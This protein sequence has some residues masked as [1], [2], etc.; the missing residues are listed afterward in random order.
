M[1]SHNIVLLSQ[2]GRLTCSP[3]KELQIEMETA[4]HLG[5]YHIAE[6]ICIWRIDENLMENL[7][8]THF[9]VNLNN[10]RTLGFWRDTVVKY[11]KVVS[12]GWIYDYGSLHIRRPAYHNWS[13]YAHLF[14]WK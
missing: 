8:E 6:V 12:G 4:Y 1:N 5:I 9:V 3:E 13:S 2:H 10:G 7:D 14:K 11:A